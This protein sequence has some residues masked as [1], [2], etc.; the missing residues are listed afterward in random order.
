[1]KR[2]NYSIVLALLVFSYNSLNGQ[3][4]ND[5]VYYEVIEYNNQN[6]ERIGEH[7]LSNVPV[8]VSNKPVIL[9]NSS[10]IPIKLFFH[11][12]SFYPDL[13]EF[14]VINPIKIKIISVPN[15]GHARTAPAAMFYHVKREKDK[16]QV[17]SLLRDG[18]NLPKIIFQKPTELPV[19]AILIYHEDC[20]SECPTPPYQQL[21]PSTITEFLTGYEREHSITLHDIYISKNKKEGQHLLYFGLASL[22]ATDKV[23]FILGRWYSQIPDKH[24]KKLAPYPPKIFCPKVF[25]TKKL[26]LWKS[27]A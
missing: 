11:S 6:T 9:Y 10:G 26:K 3:T 19:D 18:M 5:P 21:K 1:M 17:D 7:Y 20:Y 15:G 13:K 24:L 23:S 22:H 16:E 27:K 2:F 12:S 25:K 14:I 4:L 8:N